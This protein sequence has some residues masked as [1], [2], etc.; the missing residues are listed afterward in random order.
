MVAL[1]L[2]E[3]SV[4]VA[5][6]HLERIYRELS[7]RTQA[8]AILVSNTSHPGVWAGAMLDLE[9]PV[10]SYIRFGGS[11][12]WGMTAALGAKCAAPDQLVLCFTGDGGICCHITEI[13]VASK[14][15]STSSS[16]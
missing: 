11:L 14:K 8:D 12:C 15:I 7:E 2:A 5:P 3:D 16:W 1:R 10:Q 6:S 13:E 9:C 4:D